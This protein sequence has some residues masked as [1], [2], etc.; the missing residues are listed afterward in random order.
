LSQSIPLLKPSHLVQSNLLAA[1]AMLYPVVAYC[2]R[3]HS[4][5]IL[6]RSAHFLHQVNVELRV[7]VERSEQLDL[8]LTAHL[9]TSPAHPPV[10]SDSFS[11]PQADKYREMA[12]ASSH[13]TWRN[14]PVMVAAKAIHLV[15]RW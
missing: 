13:C 12:S 2:H 3:M 14:H 11:V 8:G 1:T 6:F 7:E 4:S 15:G 10:L 9:V 5:A